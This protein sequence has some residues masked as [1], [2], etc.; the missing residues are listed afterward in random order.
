MDAARDQA[1]K[2]MIATVT[3][4]A[5]VTP[6]ASSVSRLTET[7]ARFMTDWEMLTRTVTPEIEPLAVGRWPEVD[8]EVG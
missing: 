7:L 3:S 2:D 1:L 6:D 5:G 8:D 4:R